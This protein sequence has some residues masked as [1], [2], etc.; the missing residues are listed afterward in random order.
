MKSTSKTALIATLEEM[1]PVSVVGSAGDE[2]AAR[3]WLDEHRDRC[4]LVIIDISLQDEAEGGFAL[5]DWIQA[6][7]EQ[8]LLRAGGLQA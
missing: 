7:L 2:S 6:P 5:D 1:A 4:D 8:A 3:D